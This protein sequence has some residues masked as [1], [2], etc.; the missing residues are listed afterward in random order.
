MQQEVILHPASIIAELK[1]NKVTHV[2]WL[3]GQ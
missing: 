3:P 1:K 2:V